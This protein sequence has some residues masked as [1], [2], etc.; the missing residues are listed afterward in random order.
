MPLLKLV[1]RLIVSLVV[2]ST[3]SANGQVVEHKIDDGLAEVEGFAPVFIRMEDQLFKQ[4]G[5]YEAFCKKVGDAKRLVVREQVVKALQLKADASF[6]AVEESLNQLIASGQVRGV[7]RYWIVNGFAC[8]ATPQGVR[9][10][11]A[12]KPVGFV[13]RQRFG[14]Q[15]QTVD[16]RPLDPNPGLTQRYQRMLSDAASDQEVPFTTDGIEIPWNLKTVRADRAWAAHGVTGKGVL[17]AVLDD[18]M[19]T[20]PALLASLWN[21]PNETLNGKD[22]DGNGYIDDVFGYNFLNNTPYAVTP[23]GHRHGTLCASVIAARPTTGDRA[24]AAGLAPRAR[25]MPLV[26]NGRLLA[27]EYA[28]NN[29]ADILSMSYTFEPTEMGQYRGLYRN[30]HEHLAA[31]GVVS[32]GG[33]GNYAKRW[34]EG[35]QIGSPKDIPCVIAAGGIGSDGNISTFSSRGPVSWQGIRYYDT[36]ANEDNTVNKPDVTACNAD[37]PMWTHRDVWTGTRAR[38][39]QEVVRT[40]D[41]GYI[42]VTG[43]RGNSYA[44]PHV[45][46]VAAL[47][48]EANPDLPVWELQRLLQAT[49]KDMGEPGHDATYGHGMIQADN[50]VQAAIQLKS[51]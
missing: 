23:L 48:L 8:E 37:F 40:D 22:D 43:P 34:P 44:G 25:V 30:A 35:Q 19:M 10:L 13:Y 45:A 33:A 17:V 16:V 49:C 12:M 47:M 29:G 50:A 9:S 6:N 14:A 7:Q 3:L 38:R 36:Q 24:I 51:R 39:I 28:L 32:V 18:G 2:L 21:N 27:Y 42:F 11:A 26:G 15:H 5:D 4:A 20:I 31:A 1:Y 41:A 46:G